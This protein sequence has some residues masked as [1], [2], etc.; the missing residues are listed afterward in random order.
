MYRHKLAR[1]GNGRQIIAVDVAELAAHLG[2]GDAKNSHPERVDSTLMVDDDEIASIALRERQVAIGKGRSKACAVIGMFPA[3]ANQL[4]DLLDI[5]SK[6]PGLLKF[7]AA[8]RK[9]GLVA[10]VFD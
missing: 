7:V 9:R 10:F 4:P 3:V 2:C 5:N 8:G 6:P 1:L